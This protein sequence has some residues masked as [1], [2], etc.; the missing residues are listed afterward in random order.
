MTT[1]SS[2]KRAKQV[3]RTRG[4]TLQLQKNPTFWE[5]NVK[6][7]QSKANLIKHGT[8]DICIQCKIQTNKLQQ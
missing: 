4:G 2:K 1:A 6:M 3:I 8:W 5:Y 7:V